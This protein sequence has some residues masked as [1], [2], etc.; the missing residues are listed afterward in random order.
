MNDRRNWGERLEGEIATVRALLRRILN[1]SATII[2]IG[3]RIMGAQEEF[4]QALADVVADQVEL[5]DEI[6]VAIDKINAQTNDPAILD[7]TR[8]LHDVHAG[9]KAGF[10]TLK[11]TVDAGVASGGA[12]TAPP[13]AG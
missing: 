2:K 5:T 3:E 12:A 6:K 4:K 13:A 10:Q 9:L 7:A 1:Q 8:Q 11:N